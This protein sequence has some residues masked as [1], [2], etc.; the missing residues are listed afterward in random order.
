LINQGFASQQDAGGKIEPLSGIANDLKLDQKKA[1]V[2]N[3]EI[4]KIV[5]GLLGEKPTE[6]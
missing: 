4:A 6:F 3:E 1:P 2:V 5:R